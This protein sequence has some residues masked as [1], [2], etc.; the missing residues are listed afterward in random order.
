MKR[1]KLLKD[2]PTFKAGDEFYTDSNN[3]LRL[4]GRYIIA[5][6]HY[7]LEKFPNILKDW[8][9]EVHE[10]YKRWRAELGGAYYYIYNSGPI[11]FSCDYGDMKSDYLYKIGNYFKTEEEVKAYKEYLIARQVLLDDAEGG[12][13]SRKGRNWHAHYDDIRHK[14]DWDYDYSYYPGTIYFATQKAL[15]ES[16]K[17]HKDQWEIVRKYEMGEM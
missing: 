14:M 4:K 15:E 6:N 12:K 7:T 9:E 11:D 2:L 16:I 3:D 10:E 13:F 5:Y 17:K 1:Y 8:L